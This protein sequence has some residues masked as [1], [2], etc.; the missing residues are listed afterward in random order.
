MHLVRRPPVPWLPSCHSVATL[1]VWRCSTPSFDVKPGPIIY[2]V[3]LVFLVLL[4][5][6]WLFVPRSLPVA[7][8]VSPPP[9]Q[10]SLSAAQVAYPAPL[11]CRSCH[12]CTRTPPRASFPRRSCRCPRAVRA[13]FPL[14]GC[15]QCRQP[16]HRR[17]YR[18]HAAAGQSRSGNACTIT[19]TVQSDGTLMLA[20]AVKG[21]LRNPVPPTR[22]PPRVSSPSRAGP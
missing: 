17:I 4:V 18:R 1:A 15:P 6:Q 8:T 10:S 16:R 9:A 12:R 14:G 21:A 5:C 20:F 22:W 13:R 11:L 3:A 19:P 2:S 7:S